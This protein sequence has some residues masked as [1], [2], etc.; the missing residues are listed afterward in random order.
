[1]IR[2]KK[3]LK[4][5]MLYIS[6]LS[7]LIAFFAISLEHSCYAKE[8]YNGNLKVKQLMSLEGEGSKPKFAV[9]YKLES[10][11]E[12]A[13]MPENAE[14][15]VYIFTVKGQSEYELSFNFTENGEYTYLLYQDKLENINGFKGDS[16]KYKLIFTVIKQA[17]GE[18]SV[19]KIIVDEKGYKHGEAEFQNTYKQPKISDVVKEPKR[20]IDA[21]KTLP[22]TGRISYLSLFAGLN[23]ISF[24]FI[25]FLILF[26][27]KQKDEEEDQSFI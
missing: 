2:V 12:N 10:V 25:I 26:K 14:K 3:A 8:T 5:N 9:S 22:K 21:V 7:L 6:I 17:S 24:G 16:V 11:S 13:P 18:I 23:L 27:K 1:M 15:G 20:I 19:S 4:L